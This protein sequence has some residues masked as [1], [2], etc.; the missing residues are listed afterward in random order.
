MSDVKRISIRPFSPEDPEF[1]RDRGHWTDM[2][3]MWIAADR[4]DSAVS[5]FT[6]ELAL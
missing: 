3:G 2:T 1:V 6:G 5:E 4:R